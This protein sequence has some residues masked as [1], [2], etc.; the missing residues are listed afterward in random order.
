MKAQTRGGAAIE[1]GVNL[2][3][4]FGLSWAIN[5]W[6]LP[7]FGMQ[8]SL[9]ALWGL[10]GIFTA[11]SIMRQFCLRRLFEWLRI[12]KAP[13][14][15]L[16]IAQELAAERNR[17]IISEGYDLAHDDQYHRGE[18]QRAA[19]WYALAGARWTNATLPPCD[20]GLFA[21]NT[22]GWPWDR[23]FWRPTTARRDLVKAGA[24]IIAAIG[25]IDR[26]A[27]QVRK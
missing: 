24:L 7:L 11:A 15:F 12:R 16:Y 19:A 9:G 1:T 13:P 18:L 27:R 10:G 26:A 5:C 8:P 20:L 6:C 21:S 17:Q 23:S 22:Y 14:E 25:R 4:G 3:V 2:V